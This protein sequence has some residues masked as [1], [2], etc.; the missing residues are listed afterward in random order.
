MSL[1]RGSAFQLTQAQADWVLVVG[2]RWCL[3]SS[4]SGQCGKRSTPS[5]MSSFIGSTCGSPLR[6]LMPED[7]GAKVGMGLEGLHPASPGEQS[8]AFL[9]LLVELGRCHSLRKAHGVTCGLL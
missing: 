5:S 8:G 2:G 4:Q 7:S 9:G 1:S 3:V 6:G